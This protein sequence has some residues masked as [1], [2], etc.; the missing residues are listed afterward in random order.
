MQ[1]Y[2]R[3]KNIGE[4]FLEITPETAEFL[5]EELSRADILQSDDLPSNV[6]NI[7]STVTYRDDTSGDAHT[8]VLVWPVEADIKKDKVSIMTPIGAALIGLT[9]GDGISWLTN[10]NDIKHLT[11]LKVE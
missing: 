7:G 3:L 9:E 8:F 4:L 1:H 2:D 11:V 6:V 5:L 10:K